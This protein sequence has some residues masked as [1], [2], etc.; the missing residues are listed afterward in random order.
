[1]DVFF[2]TDNLKVFLLKIPKNLVFIMHYKCICNM[3][4]DIHNAI[5]DLA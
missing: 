3:S 4:Q 1:M 5:W 2:S